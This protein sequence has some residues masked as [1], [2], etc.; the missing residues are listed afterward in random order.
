MGNWSLAW[1]SA[2]PP[3]QLQRHSPEHADSTCFAFHP[4][5]L[6]TCGPRILR[7][8]LIQ[9]WKARHALAM[10][11]Q[12]FYVHCSLFIMS[13]IS[14]QILCACYVAGGSC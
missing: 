10:Q 8:P 5:A 12:A 3:I 7:I 13:N 2:C 14:K 11:Q 1:W 9:F 4:H 6:S